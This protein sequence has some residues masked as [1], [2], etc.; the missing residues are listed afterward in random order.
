M[1][2]SGVQTELRLVLCHSFFHDGFRPHEP[3]TS[4]VYTLW[5][6]SHFVANFIIEKQAEL[7]EGSYFAVT[8][9]QVFDEFA[10]KFHG[11]KPS[12]RQKETVEILHNS[13][14]VINHPSI[15]KLS[16]DESIF[17]ICDVM[18]SLSKFELML[19]SNIPSKREKAEE[20]Y[21][22]K[23]PN[24][25]IPYPIYDAIQMEHLLRSRYP[26]LCKLVDERIAQ[27]RKK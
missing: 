4:K 26:D 2:S 5:L 19:I 3:V 13:I 15:A 14:L 6:S 10:F 7:P 18:Y 20:F 1:S 21:H 9:K 25:K 27:K 8:S 12:F 23:D 17:V 24:A 11:S 16:T 22:K